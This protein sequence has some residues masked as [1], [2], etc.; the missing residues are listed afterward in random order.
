MATASVTQAELDAVMKR[1]NDLLAK[2]FKDGYE[3]GKAS[4]LN[5]VQGCMEPSRAD[6]VEWKKDW[7]FWAGDKWPVRS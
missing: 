3:A 2:A 7:E 5:P 1:L 4:L 6:P